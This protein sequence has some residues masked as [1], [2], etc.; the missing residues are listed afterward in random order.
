MQL[1]IRIGLA[2]CA[3]PR[4]RAYAAALA[5]LEGAAL[6]GV[7]DADAVRAAQLAAECG[8]RHYASL[9]EL[10]AEADALIVAD[11]PGRQRALAEA[12][13]NAGLP[14]LIEPPL[15]GTLAEAQALVAM[16][17][18]AGAPLAVAFPL[19]YSQPLAQLRAAVQAGTLGDTLMI[20]V[21]AQA[22]DPGDWPEQPATGA[23]LRESGHAADLLGWIWGREVT[24]VYAEAASRLGGRPADDCNTLLIALAGGISASLDTS[25]SRPAGAWP[26]ARTLA[27]EVTGTLGVA[28]A[29]AFAQ[30]IELYAGGRGTWQQ[31]GDPLEHLMLADWLAA[32]REGRPAPA[33]PADGLRALQFA[34][35]ALRSAELHLPVQLG[36]S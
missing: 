12:A 26:G 16:C 30:K 34:L 36:A 13:A 33:G 18:K 24:Q 29:D 4:S 23:L 7:W 20:R 21:T 10:L 15:A 17:D 14:I 28:Q 27:L 3:H 22:S 2:G 25:W 5:E 8:A 32:L 35:A 6:A 1:S 19:R 11:A 9:P 31:W